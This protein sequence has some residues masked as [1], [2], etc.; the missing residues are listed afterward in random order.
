MST[1]VYPIEMPESKAKTKAK[2]KSKS[3]KSDAEKAKDARAGALVTRF[4]E[5]YQEC[6]GYPA[7]YDRFKAFACSKKFIERNPTD[8]EDL[9]DGLFRV[10]RGSF[11]GCVQGFEILS[12]GSAW[13]VGQ[14]KQDMKSFDTAKDSG[15]MVTMAE[16]MEKYPILEGV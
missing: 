8:A 7:D 10:W 1:I 3:S 16:M 13:V 12:A 2:S 5:G 14:L 6:H 15:G 9:V 4:R 11:Q